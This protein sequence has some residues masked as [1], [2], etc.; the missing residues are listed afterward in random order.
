ML[1]LTQANATGAPPGR[2]GP[3]G[4][5]VTSVG[6]TMAAVFGMFA[7]KLPGD[8]MTQHFAIPVRLIRVAS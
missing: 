5:A 6:V 1:R 4:S 7:G 8:E 3:A 2:G